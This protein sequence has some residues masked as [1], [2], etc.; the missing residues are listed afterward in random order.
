MTTALTDDEVRDFA[1]AVQLQITRDFAPHW[2]TPAQVVFIPPSAPIPPAS[3]LLWLTDRS[4]VPGDLGYHIDKTVP[5]G[6]VAVLDCRDDDIP[7]TRAASHEVLEMLV[8]PYVAQTV[9]WPLKAPLGPTYVAR[10]V[11]DPVT[12]DHY[13]IARPGGVSVPVAAFVLPSWYDPGGTAPFAFPSRAHDFPFMLSRGGFLQCCRAG[14]KTW[15]L[16]SYD[17]EEPPVQRDTS[18]AVRRPPAEAVS[19]P[20]ATLGETPRTT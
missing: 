8:D 14:D 1:D 19:Q 13:S 7:W 11:C 3:W 9:L 12:A 15:T 17:E 18:R 16:L 4:A 2:N 6:Y 20:K 5:Q 10:E